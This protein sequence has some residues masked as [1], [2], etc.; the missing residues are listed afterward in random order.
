MLCFLPL[1][2]L[3]CK[4]CSF[5]FRDIMFIF[6]RTFSGN[7]V[8]RPQLS[9]CPLRLPKGMT[10]TNP[11]PA[12]HCPPCLSHSMASLVTSSLGVLAPA[13]KLFA[14]RR[15]RIYASPELSQGH[16]LTHHHCRPLNSPPGAWLPLSLCFF[17]F[18]FASRIQDAGCRM[19]DGR[20]ERSAETGSRVCLN[21]VAL[22]V[23]G[24][25]SCVF[26]FARAAHQQR[27]FRTARAAASVL[28]GGQGLRVQT[29][30][31]VGQT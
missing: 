7:K 30:T 8:R 19:G 12:T 14:L 13:R 24:K 21:F 5:R 2:S 4:C 23:G 27:N 11:D 22:P 1:A 17:C 26:R 28:M 9:L 6:S 20:R 16:P 10:I 29:V 15:V 31:G 18:R 3:P 25:A